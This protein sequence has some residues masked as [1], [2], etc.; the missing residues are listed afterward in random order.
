[1]P[2]SFLGRDGRYHPRGSFLTSTGRY[3]EPVSLA[4]EEKRNQGNVTC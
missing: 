1:L 3:E 2:G 4:A